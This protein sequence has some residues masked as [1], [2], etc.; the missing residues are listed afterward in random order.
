MD[1]PNRILQNTVNDK[2]YTI[3]LEYTG[4]P[5]KQYVIRFNGAFISSDSE[6]NGAL[7]LAIFHQGERIGLL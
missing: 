6:L 3:A 1:Q 2:R 5:Q 4:H 7:M